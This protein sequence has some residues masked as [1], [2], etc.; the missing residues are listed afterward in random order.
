[1]MI[2]H[3]VL[4]LG[5]AC[6]FGLW[7]TWGVGANDLG[8]VMSTTIGSKAVSTRTAVVIAIVFEF[9]GAIIGGGDVTE[10]MR[11][12]IINLNLLTQTPYILIWGMLAVLLAG[13]VWMTLARYYG[14]PVSITN[15]IVGSVIGFG[16][17]VLGVDAI[18][19][20][21]VFKIALSWLCSPTIA[22]VL[23]FLLF[24]SI[25]QLILATE[26]PLENAKRYMP[27]YLFL[28]GI[29]LS[30]I[31]LFKTLNYFDIFVDTFHEVILTLS[32]A[33]IIALVGIAILQRIPD[34]SSLKRS[35]RFEIIERMFAILMAFT[36]CAMVFAHGSNDVAVAVGPIT[37]IL[38]MVHQPHNIDSIGQYPMWLILLG[39]FGV[40]AGFLTYGRRVIETVGQG[41]T[42]LTPS[43]AFAAT[44]AAAFTIVVS[45]STGIPL[46]A[47]QT[48]VGAVFGVGLARGIGALDVVVIRNIVLSWVVTLPAASIL[49]ISF[50]YLLRLIL[51]PTLPA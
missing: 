49:T 41:I 20:S 18:Q 46:S 6:V 22:G 26:Q 45:T 5:L 48:L 42:A 17:V 23:A 19:W 9:A 29:I 11:G 3:G 7:M 34:Y 44:L 47:T 32:F 51:T 27:F 33:A 2:D 28:V 8:N 14:F 50:Y 4:Y 39:T 40:V 36:A 21:Y 31:T 10:T 35:D 43:R 37:I 38:E 24:K 30:F 16:L 13:M 15:A 12:G 1:M 25:Q